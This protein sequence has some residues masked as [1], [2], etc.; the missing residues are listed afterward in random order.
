MAQG[1]GYV[2]LSLL[3]LGM[4]PL[5]GEYTGFDKDELTCESDG[6]TRVLEQLKKKHN[7]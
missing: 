3:I 5:T 2:L 6:K 7:K 4:A 1:I